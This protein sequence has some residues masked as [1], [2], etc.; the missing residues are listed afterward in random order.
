MV[1]AVLNPQ[2]TLM[3]LPKID[4]VRTNPGRIRQGRRRRSPSKSQNS[5]PNTRPSK[6]LVMGEVKLLRRGVDLK[7][8]VSRPAATYPEGISG[9]ASVPVSQT[10]RATAIIRASS[11]KVKEINGE[12][13]SQLVDFYAG[14]GF[15]T[16][17]PPSS[18]PMP[19]FCSKKNDL[20]RSKDVT[21]DLMKLLRLD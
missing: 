6:A 14:G 5:S 12:H 9:P 4:L 3:S 19:A 20:P 8:T 11:P 18:L 17:P 13:I 15:V 7:A 16:S 21:N 2:D 10:R 1:V